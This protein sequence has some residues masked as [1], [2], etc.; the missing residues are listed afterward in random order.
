MPQISFAFANRS[1]EKAL[2]LL[3]GK[4][5]FDSGLVFRHRT[6][7]DLYRFRVRGGSSS[8]ESQPTYGSLVS[9][10][11]KRCGRMNNSRYWS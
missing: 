6:R 1:L 7:K 4:D 3:L 2:E 8:T 9:R 10:I 11:L 5:D